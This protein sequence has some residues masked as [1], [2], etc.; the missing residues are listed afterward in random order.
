MLAFHLPPLKEGCKYATRNWECKE[1][2]DLDKRLRVAKSSIDK[3]YKQ[4][5]KKWESVTRK[6]ELSYHISATLR[7]MIPLANNTFSK[8]IELMN[9]F[10]DDIFRGQNEFVHFDNASLPGIF[11]YAINYY[12]AAFHPDMKYTWYASS[13]VESTSE[14]KHPLQDSYHLVKNYPNNWLMYPNYP[15]NGDVMN[16]DVQNHFKSK[17][18]N[19]VDLYTSDIGFDVSIDYNEQET[20]QSPV[21]LGQIISGLLTLK[22]GGVLITK[23]YTFSTSFTISLMGFVTTL[24]DKTYITKPQTSKPDNSETYLVGIGFK[25]I[26]DDEMTMLL[27]RLATASID[28]NN[29]KPLTPIIQKSSMCQDFMD[30]IIESSSV[31]YEQTI[32][33]VEF[34]VSKYESYDPRPHD[35]KKDVMKWFDVNPIPFVK[36]SVMLRHK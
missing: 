2:I 26:S 19:M 3:P 6:Y 16:L 10:H 31:I 20:L 12:C 35:F 25:G 9:Y 24:F 29:I 8:I 27:N 4:N 33:K 7:N 21:N 28:H 22:K 18:G 34:N 1:L 5:K 32:K 30:A 36:R 15:F 17:L 11:P 23:Q 14:D 13:L